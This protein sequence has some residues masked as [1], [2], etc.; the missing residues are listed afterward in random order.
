MQLYRIIHKSTP[1]SLEDAI[2]NHIDQGWELM[3]GVACS[4]TTLH[5]GTMVWAQVIIKKVEADQL[6]DKGVDNWG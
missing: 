4:Q 2:Q 1:A 3:G 6:E 5:E